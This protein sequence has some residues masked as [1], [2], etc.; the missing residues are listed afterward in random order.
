MLGLDPALARDTPLP[1]LVAAAATGVPYV[2]NAPCGGDLPFR[3]GAGVAHWFGVGA[4]RRPLS[5]VRLARVRFAAECLAFANVPDDGDL[6]GVPRDAG[7]GWDFADVRDHYLR[8]LYGMEPDALRAKDF[9][10]YVALSQAVSGAVIAEVLGEWRRAGSRCG[11]GIV[12][13]LR[14]LA[15][16]SGWGLLDVG[17]VP[18]VAYHHLRRACAPVAVWT[19]DEGLGGIDVHVANDRPEPLDATLR[20]ALYRDREVP[21]EVASQRLAVPPHTTVRHGAEQVLGHFA[22]VSYAYRFGPPGHDLVVVSLERDGVPLSQAA[23]HPVG[24]SAAVE[25]PERLG[26][27]AS[28]TPAPGGMLVTVAGRRFVDGVRLDVPGWVPDDDAFFVEPGGARSV[29]LRPVD[30]AAWAGGTLRALNLRGRVAL[31]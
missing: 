26:L 27:N 23:R 4:Y 29:L 15:P 9:E 8:E 1:A 28:A 25:P 20:V 31:P 10:H 22:D 5:D 17:G 19:T 6:G 14:D 7:A 24:R 11:G 3:P 16:G 2:P 30:G 18:K 21:V 12:L 13:W